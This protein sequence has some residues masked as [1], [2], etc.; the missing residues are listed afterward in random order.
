MKEQEERKEET[1]V[2]AKTLQLQLDAERQKNAKN[3]VRLHK[4]RGVVQDG[5]V[6][7]LE[8][9]ALS[10]YDTVE[11][12]LEARTPAKEENQETKE[13]KDEEGKKLAEEVKKLTQNAS[14]GKSSGLSER[15]AWTFYDYFRKDPKALDVMRE[16]EPEKYKKLEADFAEQAKENGLKAE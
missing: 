5:E 14:P 15:D 11:K 2:D 4:Q 16:K 1:P 8:K 10:D 6:E 7:S 13:E 12:M 9:L 3:L